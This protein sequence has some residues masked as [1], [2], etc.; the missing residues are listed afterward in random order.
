MMY[1]FTPTEYVNLYK[2]IEIK[3]FTLKK[4]NGLTLMKI[5]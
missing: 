2:I 5:D 4:I 1:N 3:N